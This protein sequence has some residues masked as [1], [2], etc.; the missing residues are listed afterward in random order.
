MKVKENAKLIPEGTT[1][2]EYK[3]MLSFFIGSEGL[4]GDIAEEDD[5]E[6]GN[7]FFCVR[8]ALPTTYFHNA[9]RPG[10]HALAHRVSSELLPLHIVSLMA[11]MGFRDFSTFF[12]LRTGITVPEDS[13]F[14]D[15]L[16]EVRMNLCNER[17][18]GIIRESKQRRNALLTEL[19]EI[20]MTPEEIR[21][22]LQMARVDDILVTYGSNTGGNTSNI[23]VDFCKCDRII[24][25]DGT[26]N[27]AIQRLQRKVSNSRVR[28]YISYLGVSDRDTADAI[29]ENSMI[30]KISSTA[31]KENDQTDN[32]FTDS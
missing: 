27:N 30:S 19:R 20:A 32:F 21:T 26:E 7:F 11:V 23:L 6:D 14:A 3:I 17:T 22:E 1:E 5:L 4:F 15:F 10:T 28:E 31:F 24:S 16:S 2:R 9:Y 18:R 25:K 29:V 13:T 8:K 12:H